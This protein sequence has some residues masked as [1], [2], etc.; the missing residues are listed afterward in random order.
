LF[1]PSLKIYD[2]AG[3][4]LGSATGSGNFGSTQTR[5]VSITPGQTYYVRVAGANTTVFGTGA[6]AL[7]LKL[8]AASPPAVPLPNTQTLNG[9]PISGGGGS[10]ER[11]DLPGNSVQA[12]LHRQGHGG[13]DLPFADAYEVAGS[14]THGR[15]SAPAVLF[16]AAVGTSDPANSPGPKRTT[17]SGSPGGD[18][19]GPSGAEDHTGFGQASADLGLAAAEARDAG[20]WEAALDQ[21]FG[22]TDG[23]PPI[24]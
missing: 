10:A 17:E 13:D 16:A 7:T 9:N 3:T 8:G 2:A 6:Y 5:T 18:L 11:T 4:L 24:G 22:D 1:A 23:S 20:T 21:W 14:A 15:E 19:G 12:I